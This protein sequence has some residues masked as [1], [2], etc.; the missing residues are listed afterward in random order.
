MSLTVAPSLHRFVPRR[1]LETTGFGYEVFARSDGLEDCIATVRWADCWCPDAAQFILVRASDDLS[2]GSAHSL[3]RAI[4]DSHLRPKFRLVCRSKSLADGDLIAILHR[5]EIGFLLETEDRDE[6]ESLAETGIL[7][8]RIDAKTAL[9]SS[10][11]TP[12]LSSARQLLRAAHDL[13]LRSIAS[14]STNSHELGDLLA[15]GFDYVSCSDGGFVPAE[16]G[17]DWQRKVA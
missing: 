1:A 2:A 7:G 10:N 4:D 8:V 15:L 5:N 11:G 12:P 13:G 3:I 17:F 16:P 6:V 14:Q 9:G